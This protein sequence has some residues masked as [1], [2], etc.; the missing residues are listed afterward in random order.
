MKKYLLLSGIFI[1]ISTFALSQSVGIG[2]GVPNASSQLDISSSSKG[3]LIPRM[4]TTTITTI[5]NPAKGLMVYDSSKNQLMVNMGTAIAPDWQT[6]VSKSGW[7]LTGNKGINLATNFIGT[8]DNSPLIIKINNAKAGFIDSGTNNT[9]MGFRTLDSITTGTDN[10][11]L[12]YKALMS[13][14]DG[15][16]NSAI[17]S[18]ALLSNTTGSYNTASG[19]GSL[20]LNSTGDLNTAYGVLSLNSNIAGSENTA[21]GTNSLY[22]NKASYNTALGYQSLAKNTTGTDNTALGLSA[23]WSNNIG[24]NN[25]AVGYE[26]LYN[27]TSDANT[28]TGFQAGYN[29]TQGYSNVAIGV[30]ALYNNADGSNLVAIGDSSLFN[31]VNAPSGSLNGFFNTAIGSKALFSNTVGT[32][33]TANGYQCLFFNTSGYSNTAYGYL[34]LSRNTTGYYNTALGSAVLFY[35]N[36]GAYNTAVGINALSSNTGSFYNTG[37]GANAGISHNLGYNNTLIGASCDVNA[38]G[39]Y[40]CVALGEAVTCTASNQARIGNSSTTT[41]GGYADWTTFSDGHYKKNIQ[42][43]VKGIDFIMKLRPVTYQLDAQGISDKLNE[44]RGKE[45]NGP[46]KISISE[47]E[48]IIFSGFVAQEVEQ[49]AKESGYDFS[50]VDTPKNENDFYGLHYGDFVVPLV[51]TVQ[52]QQVIINDLQLKIQSLEKQ[53]VIEKENNYAVQQRLLLLEDQI[54]LLLQSSNRKN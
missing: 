26:S 28:A 6:I 40:N 19:M 49:A 5:S 39:L 11:A 22:F 43:N 33:N 45:L 20:I 1:G 16:N 50:G 42:E 7:S 53:T 4:N 2:T 44:G 32:G 48:K 51:K 12:G 34:S 18:N 15:I 47:K 25:T 3:L 41:I 21:I 46:M 52:E 38:N 54:K 17:G 27:N 10:L 13:N 29:N 9:G 35:N 14:S 31:N 23:L 36:I 8:T 24:N 37:V 30:R